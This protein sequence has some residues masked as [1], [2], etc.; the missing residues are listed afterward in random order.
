M[1]G[2]DHS[3]KVFHRHAPVEATILGPINQAHPAIPEQAFQSKM[4]HRP[5]ARDGRRAGTSRQTA[6][7]F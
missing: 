5:T 2:P 4:L 7:Y 1:F 6:G 3:V